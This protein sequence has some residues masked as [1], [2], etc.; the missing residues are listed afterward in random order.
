MLYI[1]GE[2]LFLWQLSTAGEAQAKGLQ[3]HFRV[4]P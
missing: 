1:V 2:D 4:N 3:M